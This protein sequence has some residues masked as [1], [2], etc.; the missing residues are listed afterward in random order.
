VI[1]TILAGDYNFLEPKQRCHLIEWSNILKARE[2]KDNIEDIVE[3]IINKN[4]LDTKRAK[5][6]RAFVANGECTK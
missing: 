4:P 2:H 1:I 6:I 5:E 3:W